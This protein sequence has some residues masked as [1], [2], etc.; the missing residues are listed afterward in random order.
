MY[1]I[2]SHDTSKYTSTV[3]LISFKKVNE[4]SKCH[5]VYVLQVV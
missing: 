2:I 1:G 5:L 4:R 3:I